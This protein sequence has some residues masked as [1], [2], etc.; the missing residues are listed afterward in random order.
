MQVPRF[1]SYYRLCQNCLLIHLWGFLSGSDSKVSVC[2]AG[3]PDSIPG[4]GRSSGKG[5]GSPLVFLR[6]KSHGPR[7][8]VG[9]RPWGHK[10]S[11]TTLLPWFLWPLKSESEGGVTQSCPTLC[12]LID[13]GLPRSSLHGNFQAKVLQWVSISFSRGSFQPRDQS[14]VSHIVGRFFTIWATR[15]VTTELPL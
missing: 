1:L 12:D 2:N 15:E 4:L 3:D 9:Y 5:N 8:L 11:D 7:S 10:E 6:G 14:W 13:Y